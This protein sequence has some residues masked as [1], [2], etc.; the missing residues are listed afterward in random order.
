MVIVATVVLSPS[1]WRVVQM[2]L[3][4]LAFDFN[5][6]GHAGV[7]MASFAL[8][9]FAI[10][11]LRGILRR[12]EPLEQTLA[13]APLVAAMLLLV[14][15]GNLLFGAALD[16]LGP[17]LARA[18]AASVYTAAVSLPMWMLVAW[19]RES[20]RLRPATSHR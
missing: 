15:L 3:V 8:V 2:A 11:Q 14:A 5:S 13:S 20:Q 9:A 7:G 1:P 10:G 6:G 19:L 17:T 12:L 16:P 4:G 18:V